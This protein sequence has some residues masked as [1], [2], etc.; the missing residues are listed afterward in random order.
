MSDISDKVNEAEK[1]RQA[2]AGKAEGGLEKKANGEFFKKIAQLGYAAL[3]TAGALAI[4]GPLNLVSVTGSY[5]LAHTIL[6]RKN[7][8][9]KGFRKELHLGNAMTAF[10]YYLFKVFNRVSPGNILFNSL[11]ILGAG[12]PVFNAVFLPVRY[13]T[14]NYT[15]LKLLK[16]TFTFKLPKAFSEIKQLYKKEYVP[17]TKRTYIVSPLIIGA[18][19]FAPFEYQLP[20]TSA[21]R[22]AYRLALGKGWELSYQNNYENKELA[23]QPT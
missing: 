3:T 14:Y 20:I 12:I 4:A 7:L 2:K 19:N 11:F 17:M 22:L 9:Y 1:E 23:T 13:F 15:P 10:L 6:N 21:G 5:L 16:D 8:T 18:V